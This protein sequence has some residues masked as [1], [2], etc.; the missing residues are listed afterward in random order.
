MDARLAHALHVGAARGCRL[1]VTTSRSAGMRGSS[2][3]VVSSRDSNVRRLRLL[4][5]SSGVFR[6]SARSSSA[7]VVHLDQHRHAE[8]QRQRLQF[9]HLRIV[10]TRRR[11]AG[12]S[13][14]PAR[15][16]RTPGTA[17]TMKSLRSTGSAQAA[18]ACCRYAALPWKNCRSVSTDRQAAPCA[19][20]SPRSRPGRNRARSTP[21]L[22]LA[23]LISAITAGLPSAELRAQRADE[24][25]R[26]RLRQ[27]LAANHRRITHTLRRRRSPRA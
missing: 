17:S 4:M 8:L 15:A 27:R 16:P 18:R 2:P 20:S 21:L 6:R 22:G 23:F 3:S 19:R 7:R 5:P 12:C 11:S 9:A 13:R 14:R 1:S 25:A 10:E 24:V 26:R